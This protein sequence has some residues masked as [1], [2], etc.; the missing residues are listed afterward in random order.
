MR[1]TTAKLTG[2]AFLTA[3]MTFGS[4]SAQAARP[5]SGG[6]YYQARSFYMTPPIYANMSV[7]G[8]PPIVV[9]EP[10][11]TYPAPV[12]GYY[13]PISA[14]APL[15]APVRPP[16]PAPAPAFSPGLPLGPAPAP[17]SM[18]APAPAPQARVRER[19]LSTPFHTRY[20]YNVEYPGGPEYK[21]RY[22]R[23]GE[24]VRFSERWDH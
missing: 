13:F 17:A 21:Y 20:R 2:L 5:I 9:Y 3:A 22:Q 1:R 19:Q 18:G 16:A 23:D 4:I 15:A 6:Y 7:F 14:P 12:A 11:M 10:V 24:R 8:Q